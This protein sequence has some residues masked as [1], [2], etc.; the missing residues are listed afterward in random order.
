LDVREK[1]IKVH[2]SL[3]LQHA[4]RHGF[5]LIPIILRNRLASGF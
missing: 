5:G 2:A 3:H 4:E 1:V